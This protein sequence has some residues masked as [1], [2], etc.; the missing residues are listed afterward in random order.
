MN[1][2]CVF[3]TTTLQNELLH[4]LHVMCSICETDLSKLL[5]KKLRIEIASKAVQS[6]ILVY[7]KETNLYCLTFFCKIGSFVA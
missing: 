1:A 4:V 6:I 5:P 7:P 3:F 2:G